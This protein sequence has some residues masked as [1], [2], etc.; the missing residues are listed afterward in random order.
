[1]RQRLDPHVVDSVELPGSLAPSVVHLTGRAGRSAMGLSSVVWGLASAQLAAGQPVRIWCCDGAA[2][3]ECAREHDV[4]AASVSSFASLG[5]SRLCFSPAMRRAATDTRGVPEVLHQHGIWT[6]AS[7]VANVWRGRRG[8]TVLA[9]HGSLEGWAL[10]KSPLRKAL[11]LRLFEGRNLREANCL[12]ATANAEVDNIREVGLEGPVALIPNG[13]SRNWIESTGDGE[14]FRE[15][16]GIRLGERI[17]LFLSRITPKKGLPLLI[18]AW[19]TQRC[20]LR[21]WCLLIAGTD[22]FS[23]RSALIA[24]VEAASLTES[25]RFLPPLYGPDKRDAFEA[26]EVFALPSYSEGSPMAV[27]DAL[28]AGVPV[29]TTRK[30]PWEDLVRHQCGW[31]VPAEADAIGEVLADIACRSPEELAASGA[32]GRLLVSTKYSWESAA[33]RCADVYSWLLGSGVRPECV[34]T[35]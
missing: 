5:P 26:A 17:V 29:L 25:V 16:A 7:E 3:L 27:L 28:G 22:E 4:P 24:Q 8:P 14:R 12:H 10:R 21:G 6:A 33:R 30:T 20:R 11:A 19:A 31:W 35:V 23:H 34:L 2:A 18:E 13:V 32:R 1:M 15:K 9:P